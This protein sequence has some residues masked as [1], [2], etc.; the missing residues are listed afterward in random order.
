MTSTR[1]SKPIQLFSAWLA[2]AVE[3]DG[4]NAKAMHVATVSAAGRPSGRIVILRKADE[5]GFAND[6][7]ERPFAALTFFWK[8][9]RQ[10]RIE[11][12]IEQT[13]DS[14]TEALFRNR[15]REAQI[16]EWI[17]EHMSHAR[18]SDYQT[19]VD[20]IR[21]R[22]EDATVPVPRPPFFVGYRLVCDRIEFW[23]GSRELG[24]VPSRF[25]FVRRVEDKASEG[26]AGTNAEEEWTRTEL[27][28]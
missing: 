3:A 12:R 9:N 21:K 18:N 10:V 22:F 11:G 26:A 19:T 20:A 17:S 24:G 8:Q 13:P 23:E 14:E 27:I 25:E 5:N 6:L 15:R 7:A 1:T 16:G 28:G 2:E 4:L